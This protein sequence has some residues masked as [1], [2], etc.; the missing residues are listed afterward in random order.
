MREAD[1]IRIEEYQ[2]RMGDVSEKPRSVAKEIIFL[3][4]KKKS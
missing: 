4:A 2:L 1:C 3:A